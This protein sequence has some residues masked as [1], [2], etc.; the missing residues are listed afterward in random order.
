[1]VTRGVACLTVLAADLGALVGIGDRV[2][3]PTLWWFGHWDGFLGGKVVPPCLYFGGPI[4]GLGG[5]CP[6]ATYPGEG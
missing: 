3:A 5:L 6:T 1:M 2:L 4:R